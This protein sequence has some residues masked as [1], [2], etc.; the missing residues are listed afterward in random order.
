MR[1]TITNITVKIAEMNR[2]ID[3]LHPFCDCPSPSVAKVKS[4]PRVKKKN[5]IDTSAETR[6]ATT[7]LHLFTK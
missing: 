2:A 4:N 6:P 5:T 3:I 1:V 7:K